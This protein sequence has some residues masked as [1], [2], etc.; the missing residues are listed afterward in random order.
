MN[1]GT[2]T[3]IIV[4]IFASSGFWT[5]IQTVWTRSSAN[6][7][8]EQ[9][10]ILAIAYRQIID[11]CDYYMKRGHIAP[12]EYKE[13]NKYLYEPYAEMGGNGTAARLMDEVKKLPI[14]GGEVDG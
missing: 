6:K 14:K 9:R 4:A 3:A 5:F 8:A 2:I 11:L 13:L 10:L 1:T 7:S 12:D